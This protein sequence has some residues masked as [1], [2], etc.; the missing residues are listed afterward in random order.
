MDI[1][2]RLGITS[3][4]HIT[5]GMA[6]TGRF[7]VPGGKGAGWRQVTTRMSGRADIITIGRIAMATGDGRYSHAKAL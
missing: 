1:T 6:I 3:R 7:V 2:S 5:R 4:M